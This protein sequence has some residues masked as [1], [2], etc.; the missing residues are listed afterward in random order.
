MAAAGI[1]HIAGSDFFRVRLIF[2][3][4]CELDAIG[5]KLDAI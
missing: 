5:K 4:S 3:C 1:D 2:D